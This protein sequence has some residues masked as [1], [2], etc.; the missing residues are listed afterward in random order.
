M[1]RTTHHVG[2]HPLAVLGAA[3]VDVLPGLVGA[4]EADGLDRRVVTDEVHG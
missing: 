1:C 4:H 3:L 2:L